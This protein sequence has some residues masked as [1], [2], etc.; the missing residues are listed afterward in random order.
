MR[1]LV[2]KLA[3]GSIVKTQAEAKASGQRYTMECKN[4][5]EKYDT[6]RLTETQ[7]R[8]RRSLA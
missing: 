6:T 5:I 7:A 1:N 8:L 3:D 4:I 2:F